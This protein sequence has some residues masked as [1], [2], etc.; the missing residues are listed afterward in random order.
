MCSGTYPLS[1]FNP[2]SYPLQP[3]DSSETISPAVTRACLAAGSCPSCSS[4]FR[5]GVA[6]DFRAASTSAPTNHELLARS[7][8]SATLQQGRRYS[9]RL[10][11]IH[12]ANGNVTY[13]AQGSSKNL[14][15]ILHPWRYLAGGQEGD[16]TLIALAVPALE[17]QTVRNLKAGQRSRHL[18]P[19]EV[20]VVKIVSSPE[21]V[22]GPKT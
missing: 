21:Y 11:A 15:L 20:G 17:R 22:E 16:A 2:Q 13:F 5:D 7:R 12:Y 18:R 10:D 3:P 6:Y 4:R 19:R 14:R 9:E 8:A 1:D